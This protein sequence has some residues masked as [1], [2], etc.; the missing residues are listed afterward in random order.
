M[1][2]RVIGVLAIAA[3]L[4]AGA[5]GSAAGETQ[6][7]AVPGGAYADVSAHELATVLVKKDFTLLNVHVPYEGE[8]AGT[9][10]FIPFDA[11]ASTAKLPADRAAPLVVYCR[12]GRMSAIAARALVGSGYTNVRNVAGGMI[13]WERAGYPLRHERR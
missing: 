5:A 6:Q 7:V 2:V 10:L 3:A 9:D 12:S 11:I 1:S 13:A 4:G 8:I